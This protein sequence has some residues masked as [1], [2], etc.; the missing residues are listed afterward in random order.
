MG[1]QITYQQELFRKAI[2]ISSLWMV[3]VMAVFPKTVN[4]LL[5]GGLLAACIIT[6]YGNYRCWPLFTSTYGYLFGRMLR[7]KEKQKRA[8]RLSGAPYVIGAALLSIAFF[9]KVI[10]MTAFTAMLLGD[11]AAALI[12]RKFGH[13]KFNSGTKSLE[14]S[15]SCF[16]VGYA[17]VLFFY[18]LYSMP[19]SFAAS[20]FIGVLLATLAEAYENRIHIDD[21]FSIPLIIGLAL[22]FPMFWW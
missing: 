17:T 3:V 22:S 14:G 13:H 19:F 12:G 21:N 10:A 5:F 20:G 18:F 2:H 15:L 6:E 1:T 7:E 8:F 16:W 11:T 4:I 9:P